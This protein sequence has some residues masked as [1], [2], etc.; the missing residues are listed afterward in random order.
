MSQLPVRVEQDLKENFIAACKS[1][2]STASQELR[3]FMREYVK[4]YNQLELFKTNV[5]K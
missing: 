2:D 5:K 4:K 3:K 1:Q